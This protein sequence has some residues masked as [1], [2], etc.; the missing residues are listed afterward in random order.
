MI[1]FK[2]FHGEMAV[3][4]FRMDKEHVEYFRKIASLNGIPLH[5]VTSKA[6]GELVSRG[7]KLKLKSTFK[8]HALLKRIKEQRPIKVFPDDV[9]EDLSA[10]PSQ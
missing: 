6:L 3:T 10:P 4:H 5:I 9:G 2:G 8:S 7:W 1:R